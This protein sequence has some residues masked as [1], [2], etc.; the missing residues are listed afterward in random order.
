MFL[1]GKS[2][3]PAIMFLSVVL[4]LVLMFSSNS[5]MPYSRNDMF[6]DTYGVYEGFAEGEEDMAA[7]AD[8]EPTKKEEK[9]EKEE[10]KTT[11]PIVEMNMTSSSDKKEAFEDRMDQTALGYSSLSNADII[12][13]FSH[14][15][16]SNKT[17]DCYSAGLTNSKGPICLTPELIGLLKTRGGNM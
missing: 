6:H 5:Y 2:I 3:V 12:D 13:K 4:L 11:E 1:K 10:K 15:D 17:A 16:S 7:G 8:T 14:V 9:K